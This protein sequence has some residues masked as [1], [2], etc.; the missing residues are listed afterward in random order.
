MQMPPSRRLD[1]LS[2]SS[3]RLVWQVVNNPRLNSQDQI[4]ILTCIIRNGEAVKVPVSE[5]FVQDGI[6]SVW[7]A[8]NFVICTGRSGQRGLGYKTPQETGRAIQGSNLHHGTPRASEVIDGFERY[9]HVFHDFTPSM[10]CKWG[11]VSTTLSRTMGS[12]MLL[13]IS[14]ENCSIMERSFLENTY[15]HDREDGIGV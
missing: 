3:S 11:R 5:R 10:I 13:N 15:L 4:N 9:K 6:D 2:S 8:I 7:N 1:A 12:E 14:C